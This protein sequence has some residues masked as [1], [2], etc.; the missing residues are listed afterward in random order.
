MND[1]DIFIQRLRQL[2]GQNCSFYGRDCRIVEI[3]MAEAHVV[4]E[5][6]EATPPIQADQYGQAISR[7]NEHIEVALFDDAGE[8]SEEL[9][10][11]L[12]SVRAS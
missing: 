11:L 1:A 4:L 3:L 6:R 9:M 2:I 8:L 7:A 10:D 5:C 12:D